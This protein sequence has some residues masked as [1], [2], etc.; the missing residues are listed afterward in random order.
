MSETWQRLSVG[1]EHVPNNDLSCNKIGKFCPV[2]RTLDT[3]AVNTRRDLQCNQVNNLPCHWVQLESMCS[4]CRS[5]FSLCEHH[6]IKSSQ[7]VHSS[8][9]LSLLLR[10]LLMKYSN[11]KGTS[12]L[13]YIKIFVLFVLFFFFLFVKWNFSMSISC[14]RIHFPPLLKWIIG[15]GAVSGIW[16]YW[17]INGNLISKLCCSTCV[18]V[19]VHSHVANTNRRKRTTNPKWKTNGT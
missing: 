12:K 4:T 11:F 7:L 6:Q 16:E 15:T 14:V 1:P 8:T 5:L 18:F 2:V 3:G 13:Y 19:I 10:L 17:M 9:P